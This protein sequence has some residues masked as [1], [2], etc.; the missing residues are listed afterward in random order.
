MPEYAWS[1]RRLVAILG[2]ILLPITSGDTAMR[3]LRLIIA[4]TFHIDQDKPKDR[5]LL[6]LPVFAA[7]YAV[8]IWAKNDSNGFNTIWRYFAWSNQALAIFAL[9]SILIW[10]MRHGKE[11][12]LWMPLL[13]LAFYSFITCSYICSAKIGLSLP[14]NTSLIIGVVFALLISAAAIFKGSRKG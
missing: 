9:S 6:A 1:L 3:S 13:P 5:I 11:K 8:L 4:D 7:V 12:Y 14:Y 2:V 10:L